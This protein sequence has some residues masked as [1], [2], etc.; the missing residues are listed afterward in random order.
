MSSRFAQW[1]LLILP[2]V[3]LLVVPPVLAHLDKGVTERHR[4]WTVW[5]TMSHNLPQIDAQWAVATMFWVAIT[6]FLIGFGAMIW[7]S[8]D[9]STDSQPAVTPPFTNFTAD[10]DWPVTNDTIE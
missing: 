8:L 6:V 9:P 3:L 10:E 7:L 1:V 5:K 2:V 4:V